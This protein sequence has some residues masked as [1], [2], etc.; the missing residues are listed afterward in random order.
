MKGSPEY[1][2]EADS[3][4]NHIKSMLRDLTDNV[5]SP[6]PRTYLNHNGCWIKAYVN[7]GEVDFDNIARIYTKYTTPFHRHHPI[8]YAT[9]PLSTEAM[10]G[11]NQ[12]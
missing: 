1:Q 3:Y 7:Y 9:E 6:L 12:L 2:A 11:F 4:H 10:K 8:A 5:A